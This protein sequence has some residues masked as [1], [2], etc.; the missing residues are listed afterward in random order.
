[1]L[2]I[3]I[4][5]DALQPMLDWLRLSKEQGLRDED[6]LRRILKL[7]PYQIEFARYGSEGLPVCGISYEEAVDFF[8][9]FDEKEFEKTRRKDW[10]ITLN[11]AWC[12]K[13]SDLFEVD[14]IKI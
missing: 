8:L 3:H 2:K 4:N 7:E 11:Y 1:M 14:I 10:N 12:K 9:H 5:T 6:A 13:D